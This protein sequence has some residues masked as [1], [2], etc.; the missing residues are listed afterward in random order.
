[1][2]REGYLDRP[3]ALRRAREFSR[4]RYPSVREFAQM[5]G[6]NC[7]EM[8]TAINAAPKLY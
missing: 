7:E 4:P 1:M 8:L 3:E 2:V 6:I 5:I